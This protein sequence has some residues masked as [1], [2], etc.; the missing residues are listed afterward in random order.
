MPSSRT[1]VV[2]GSVCLMVA[3]GNLFVG[4]TAEPTLTMV[5]VVLGSIAFLAAFVTKRSEAD[6]AAPDHAE[7]GERFLRVVTYGLAG[8]GLVAFVVAFVVAEGEARGHA[9]LHLLTG[10]VCLGLFAALAFLWHPHAGGGAASF[11]G[12]VLMLLAVAGLGALLESLGGSGYDAANAGHRIELLTNLHNMVT[13]LG[14]LLLIA[15]PLA[16]ITAVVVLIARALGRSS[17]PFS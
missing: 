11:R 10:L 7:R 4:S 8:L 1:L 17:R 3:G 6:R 12:F 5:A 14:A 16:V 13:P 9:I 2:I 15:V